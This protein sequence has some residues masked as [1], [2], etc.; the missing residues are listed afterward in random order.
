MAAARRVLVLFAHPARDRSRVNVALAEGVRGLAGVTFHDLYEAYPEFDIDVRAEQARLLEHD[1]IVWQHPLYWYS[2]PAI[3]KEWQDLV[4]EHGWAY[5][6]GGTALQ[7]K[8]LLCALTAGGRAAAYCEQGHNRYTI[9]QL[10]APIERTAALC[11]MTFLPPFVVFGTHAL[12][13]A[14]IRQQM[15]HYRATIEAL[16][17]G[18]LD[19]AAV[20]ADGCLVGAPTGRS[21]ATGQAAAPRLGAEADL[22]G[23]PGLRGTPVVGS[24][25]RRPGEP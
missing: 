21:A 5:G 2:T 19:V 25:P 4:L 6:R 11:G 20:A 17:D 1:A 7:G 8:L 3:L 10:L 18:T 23:E 9:R 16:R 22:T 14:G 15:S 24:E 12:D 13:D